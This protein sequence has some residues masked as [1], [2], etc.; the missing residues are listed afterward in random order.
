MKE[1][2]ISIIVLVYNVEKYLRQCLDSIVNQTYSELEII[3]IDDGSTDSSGY[4][5]DV[6]GGRDRR[7]KVIHQKNS[8]QAISRKVGVRKATGKYIGFVDGDDYID[9]EM[10]FQLKKKMDISR[11]DIIHTTYYRDNDKKIYRVGG[12]DREYT[13]I[14]ER[15]ALILQLLKSNI[16][17]E[18][19][20]WS[21]LFRSEILK[22]SIE[23]INDECVYGED[24]VNLYS[25]IINA[26]KIVIYNDAYY[27]Y[28]FRKESSVNKICKDNIR[29]E[30]ILWLNLVSVF[31]KYGLYCKYYYELN[32]FLNRH[33]AIGLEKISKNE[34][35]I[36]RYSFLNKDL[37]YEKKVVIWGA[38][39]VGKSYYSQISRYT[40]TNI[41]AWIDKNLEENTFEYI[42]LSKPEII[43]SLDFDMVIIAVL[44][45]L[46]A[47]EIAKELLDYGIDE[48]KI[49]WEKPGNDIM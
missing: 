12:E 22:K 4:I 29:R 7:I 5:C 21:K 2:L 28:R 39:A 11:A 31:K 16:R 36:Q 37:L 34:F 20:I 10:Y 23:D 8:G 49:V 27:Y 45:K 38:G 48:N 6:Y 24:M 33:V 44:N 25:A 32:E 15:E 1:E 17:I 47:D 42:K 14:T 43:K 40:H 19:S 26:E 41:V 46:D 18:P 35:I 3:I 9:K 13:N 30:I